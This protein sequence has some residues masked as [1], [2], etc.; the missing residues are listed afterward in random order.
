MR[1]FPTKTIWPRL[2]RLW[3]PNAGLDELEPRMLRDIGLSPGRR[4]RA[5]LK[6]DAWQ[7]GLGL[8]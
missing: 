5:D 2:N 3:Q 8:R 1:P 6:P 4:C 7:I